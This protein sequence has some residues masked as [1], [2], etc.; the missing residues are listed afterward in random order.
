MDTRGPSAEG[1]CV[2]EPAASGD[3][4]ADGRSADGA[5][6]G[7]YFAEPVYFAGLF[8]AFSARSSQQTVISF[9]TAVTLIPP[10]LI[11]QSHTGHFLVVPE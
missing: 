4:F 8:F 7:D 3:G 5:G 9:P 2:L 11:S 6:T 10:S 1:A